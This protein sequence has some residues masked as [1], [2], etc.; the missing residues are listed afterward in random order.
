MIT[1]ETSLDN[2]Q[3][4]AVAIWPSATSLGNMVS[5]LNIVTGDLSRAIRDAY[6]QYRPVDRVELARELGN[7]ILMSLRYLYDRGIDI[8]WALN[9]AARI[10]AEY[11]SKYVDQNDPADE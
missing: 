8:G 3:D 5:N 4:A 9:D 2:A 7:L 11:Y 1:H 6:D 10:Q